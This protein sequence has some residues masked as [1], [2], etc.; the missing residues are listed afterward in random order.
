M[1]SRSV[2]ERQ[3][4]AGLESDVHDQW[5]DVCRDQRWL[6]DAAGVIDLTAM[7][8]SYLPLQGCVLGQAGSIG[9]R[10]RQQRLIVLHFRP[11]PP[12]LR[13]ER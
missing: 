3:W 5:P 8:G 10:H 6:K 9:V 7:V 1:S 13:E 11:V 4:T 12:V 2:Q